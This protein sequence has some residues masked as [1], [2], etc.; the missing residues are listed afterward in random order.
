MKTTAVLIRATLAF[1]LSIAAAANAESNQA[2]LLLSY[3]RLEIVQQAKPLSESIAKAASSEDRQAI[4]QA[5][6]QWTDN[7]IA[8]IRAG[9]EKRFPG[10]SRDFFRLYV[11]RYTECEEKADAAFLKQ[12]SDALG[13][14][15]PP[16][17]YASLRAELLR[18]E[19]KPDVSATSKFLSELQTWLDVKQ[20]QTGK[21]PPLGAWLS[22][23]DA[24]PAGSAAA[25]PAVVDP[26]AAAEA[27]AGNYAGTAI[28]DDANPLEAVSAQ[29]KIRREKKVQSALTHMQQ[30]SAER[31]Q[32]EEQAAA[33]KTALAQAEADAMKNQANQMAV[34][35]QAA[36]QERQNSFGAHLMRAAVSIVGAVGGAA[37]GAIGASAGLQAADQLGLH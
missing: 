24:A 10:Q 8:E 30:V 14:A 6:T 5:A 17:D 21:A 13:L 4:G 29:E 16:K 25:P 15:T 32:Y 2:V 18:T 34:V 26:L 19:L 37:G 9:L 22:R 3:L 1:V 28:P 11:A 20:R 33:Q 35:E 27:T 31:R 23:N 36:L 12:T 7:R